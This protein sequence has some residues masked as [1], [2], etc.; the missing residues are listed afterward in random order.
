LCW[1][2]DHS[3][4]CKDSTSEGRQ[5]SN[6]A[7]AASHFREGFVELLKF[8]ELF[9][10]GALPSFPFLFSHLHFHFAFTYLYIYICIHKTNTC[11][12]GILSI[13]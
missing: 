4:K 2:E 5:E 13:P 10:S 1:Y 7:K 11:I 9:R 12:L 3:V 8:P 6:E